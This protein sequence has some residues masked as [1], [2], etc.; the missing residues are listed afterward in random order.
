MNHFINLSSNHYSQPTPSPPLPLPLEPETEA[1]IERDA[2]LELRSSLYELLSCQ[3]HSHQ[4]L[5]LSP[6]T[7]NCGHSICSTSFFNSNHQPNTSQYTRLSISQACT[8][9]SSISDNWLLTLSLN[10]FIAHLPLNC[11]HPECDWRSKAP[12]P[13]SSS[14]FSSSSPP[15]PSS[16]S[17]CSTT[18]TNSSSSS[19]L[20]INVTLQKLVFHL[21]ASSTTSSQQPHLLSSNPNPFNPETKK[22]KLYRTI[23]SEL[24]CQICSLVFDAPTTTICGHTFCRTCLLRSLDYSD[25]CPVCRT[26]MGAPLLRVLQSRAPDSLLT[27]ILSKCFPTELR[28]PPTPPTH[29]SLPDRVPLFICTLAFPRLPTF[30]HVF[31]PR[32]RLLIRR[33]LASDG[34]FGMV[35]PSFNH[36]VNPSGVHPFGTLLEIKNVDTLPDGRS[37]VEAVGLI[38]FE[39]LDHHSSDGYEM[40]DVRWIEDVSEST[41]N[42]L[43][44]EAAPEESIN[45]LCGVCR[46]FVEVLRAG[47]TPWILQRLNVRSPAL[48][49]PLCSFLCF[50]RNSLFASGFDLQRQRIPLDP[51]LPTQ[52]SSR[53][54]WQWSYPWQMT[55]RHNS[56]RLLFLYPPPST[57]THTTQ[58]S[59]THSRWLIVSLQGHHGQAQAKVDCPLDPWFQVSTHY[60][61]TCHMVLLFTLHSLIVF[62]V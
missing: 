4:H 29:L 49:S 18:S 41:E 51:H 9:H 11:P 48:S 47:S 32:Y 35:L 61:F 33:A 6:I 24:E 60:N 46:A 17:A 43:E 30:L 8:L 45:E 58:Y 52:P 26:S 44:S 2:D 38:R 36:A 7:L 55:K 14:S 57:H 28:P 39:I 37:L 25:R 12:I 21:Q 50:H 5:L 56:Y 19:P 34:R 23:L 54:G 27:N 40:A 1:E 53:I 16:S 13:S 3:S 15:P 59:R 42:R 62:L 20:A 22:T 10:L 31:E